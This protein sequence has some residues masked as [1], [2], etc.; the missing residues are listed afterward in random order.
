MYFFC[1]QYFI[2]VCVPT[3]FFEVENCFGRFWPPSGRFYYNI[4]GKE[5][6]VVGSPPFLYIYIYIYKHFLPC[7]AC[8]CTVRYPRRLTSCSYRGAAK[9][10]ARQ[11]GN[12]P[13]FMSEWREFLSA[14]CLAG[15]KSL[16][17]LASRCCWNRARLWH[18]S[19]LFFLPGRA[20]DL[21][22]PGMH[23][24]CAQFMCLY[25]CSYALFWPRFPSMDIGQSAANWV[26]G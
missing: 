16:W 5:Y 11:E 15:N 26:E 21:S 24:A 3:V 25:R 8:I 22:A 12:K 20:K 2:Y 10:L 17:Q 9:S 6:R 14:P 7:L 4:H 23:I 13:M 1:V 18:A 19:E